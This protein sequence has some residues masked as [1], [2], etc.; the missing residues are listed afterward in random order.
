MGKKA[1]VKKVQELVADDD[2][3]MT[4]DAKTT[5]AA[6]ATA[7]KATGESAK[8]T[9]E[10][11]EDEVVDDEDQEGEVVDDEDQEDEVVDD[12]DQEDDDDEDQEEEDDEDQEE[13]DD[14][15]QEEEEEDDEQEDDGK[16]KKLRMRLFNCGAVD[17]DEG[18]QSAIDFAAYAHA[19][20][21]LSLCTM[22]AWSLGVA[23]GAA[24][25]CK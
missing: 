12:E 15:D 1:A 23:F 20:S 22:F 18:A 9:G 8:A 24:S 14:E 17:V 13:E 2:T 7:D 5:D 10:S 21:I 25:S 4:E 16:R 6:D 11:A 19:F 3:K